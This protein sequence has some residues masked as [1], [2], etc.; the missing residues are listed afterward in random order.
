M[1]LRKNI[2]NLVVA[3]VFSFIIPLLQFPYLSRV[4]GTEALGLYMMSL[5]FVFIGG[6]ITN[7]GFDISVAKRIAEGENSSLQL[8]KFL[9]TVNTIK[10]ILLFISI[11]LILAIALFTD[12]Y[13]KYPLFLFWLILTIV[14]NTYT[15][16]WLLQ[17]L[18][19]IYIFSRVTIMTR[20]LSLVLVYF[21]VKSVQ[22]LNYL[23]MILTIQASLTTVICLLFIK[24]NNIRSVKTTKKDIL[25]LA[26]ESLEFFLS[27]AGVSLYSSC[28]SIFLGLMSPSLHQVAIYGVAEQLYKAGVQVFTPIVT[29]LTPYMARTKNYTIFFKL[30][31]LSIIIV[32]FGS[33]TGYFLG[34]YFIEII[35]GPEYLNAYGPLKIFMFTIIIS[36][37]GMLF[38]YPAL[39]PLKLTKVANY[40]VIYAG[41]LQ[42][43]LMIFIY[44]Y[45]DNATAITIAFTYLICDLYMTSYRIFYFKKHYSLFKYNQSND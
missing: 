7:F 27:R 43:M 4:I 10:T 20:M 13:N 26:S 38:G 2:L 3:Q 45:I 14:A 17:G 31:I 15:P 8:G 16:L 25:A 44:H 22:D 11:S 29:S 40:S 9:Y 33:F 19:K 28:G 21:L 39:I 1:S 42:L 41:C 12:H 35:Y 23:G 36:I 37:I 32:L 30:L 34:D 5:S 24:N 6:V 18:E